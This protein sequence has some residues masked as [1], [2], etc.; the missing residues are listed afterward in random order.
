MSRLEFSHVARS[1]IT[2]TDQRG[3][4]EGEGH[5]DSKLPRCTSSCPLTH[6]LR[7]DP[8]RLGLV[9]C[10]T[11]DLFQ[12]RMLVEVHRCVEMK[13]KGICCKVISTTHTH[14]HVSVD[15]ITCCSQLYH[16]PLYS[17][18]ESELPERSC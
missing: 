7:R 18:C 4:G 14:T 10:G 2:Q 1:R 16:R 15:L 3:Q 5:S 9:Y 17:S 6:S 8:L 11:S 12:Y 13:Q